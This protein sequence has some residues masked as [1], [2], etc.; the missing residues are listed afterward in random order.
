MAS[1]GRQGHMK[2]DD[3]RVPINPVQIHVSYFKL[4]SKISIGLDIVGEKLTPIASHDSCKYLPDCSRADDPNR[5]AADFKI[6]QFL[7]R[8]IVLLGTRLGPL[9]LSLECQYQTNCVLS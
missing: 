2:R 8:E 7:V 6:Y 1:Q 9:D 4:F 5:L 3:V